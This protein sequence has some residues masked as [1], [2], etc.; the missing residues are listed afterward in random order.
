MNYEVIKTIVAVS[1]AI[2]IFT[3]VGYA[4]SFLNQIKERRKRK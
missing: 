1:M 2:G 4:V 3:I